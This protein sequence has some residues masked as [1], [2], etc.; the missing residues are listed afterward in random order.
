MR[1]TLPAS[2]EATQFAATLRARVE[3]PAAAASTTALASGPGGP[4]YELGAT[5]GE[6]GMGRVVEAVDTLFGRRVALKEMR[7]GHA[8]DEATRRFVVEALVSGNLEHPGVVP[9]YDRGI[10]DGKPYYTMRRLDGRTLA[11]AI[12]AAGDARARLALLPAIVKIAHTLAFAHERGVVHRDLKPAN[13]ILGRHGEVTVIDWGI[14]RVGGL[15]D[16]VGASLGEGPDEGGATKAGAVMG[17]PSYMAPEQAAGRVDDIDERTDVFAIGAMIY[18]VLSGHAPYRGSTAV[19]TLAAALEG[20][21]PALDRVAAHAPE[22]L[23]SICERAMATDRAARFPTATELA[24]ALEEF[25]AGAVA[26]RE[27][28]AVRWLVGGVASGFAVILGLAIS[29]TLASTS[30]LFQQ[31][32]A[33]ITTLMLAAAGALLAVVEW[34]TRGRYRLLPLGAGL[35]LAT[36]LG[37]LS[38]TSAGIGQSFLAGAQ[39][40]DQGR[41][42]AAVGMGV[43]EAVG[44]LAVGSL[45]CV[46]QAF[47]WGLAARA[48]AARLDAERS[49]R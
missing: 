28:R 47:L 15:R 10:R 45:Y 1:S 44:L 41:F 37:A 19:A 21:P 34:R 14:A 29:G 39:M 48:T 27:P 11:D 43:Y 4:R 26:A 18:E 38:A 12:E 25:Q 8:S 23:R 42:W 31:G 46:A 7:E 3:E 5:L 22:A 36:F 40:D 49:A 9:V 13:V 16:I 17:T 24:Q 30:S 6:G 2:A 32:P 33:G 20:K 35:G